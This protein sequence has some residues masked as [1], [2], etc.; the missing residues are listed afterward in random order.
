MTDYRIEFRQV[1]K[2]HGKEI[3]L[4]DVSFAVP[5]GEHVAL[6]G[7]SGWGKTTALRLLAGLDAP[8]GGKISI[9]GKIVSEAGRILRP[10]HLRGIGMVFQ[11]L[12]LWPNLSVLENVRLGLAGQ[13][14]SKEEARKRANQ[15]L[16]L[17]GIEQLAG[18]KPGTLS[19]GQQQRVALARAIAP[20]PAFLFLDE[21]FSGLDL[22]LKKRLLGEIS[23]LAEKWELTVIL[24]SHDPL[25]AIG[26]CGLVVVLDEG[27]VEES[28]QLPELLERPR[29][30][31]LKIFRSHLKN[32]QDS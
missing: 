9:E 15:V 10:P 30:E 8:S 11:D 29:S 7:P 16:A 27:R 18:R 6:I 20:R 21:P 5:A 19:G 26:L 3:A 31:T 4:K 14:L 1:S 32:F 23:I 13:N 12:A 25:D 22:I 17:C 2:Y 24:V 28:G